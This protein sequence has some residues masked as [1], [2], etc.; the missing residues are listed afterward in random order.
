MVLQAEGIRN[1]VEHWRRN[2][3]RV[4]GTLIWQL[5]DCWP[6]ASWS[7]LDYFG[8]WKALHYAAKRFYAPVLLSVEDT[9]MRM[10]VHVTSDRTEPWSGRLAWRL[11]ALDG[12]VLDSGEQAVSA[13]PLAD[14]LLANLDFS[15]LLDE[16]QRRRTVFVCELW[17]GEAR[18]SGCVSTFVPNKHIELADPGIQVK[19][20][21]KDGQL[22]IRL[23]AKSLARFVELEFEEADAVFSDNYFDLSPN[24]P[25]A[26]SALL[27]LGW[28]IEQARRA[29]KI[30]S[31]YDSF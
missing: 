27:P 25:I 5:N 16:L 4:S 17:Q 24:Q 12:A 10:A 8:R 26:V 1:G 3:A 31:L 18:L 19:V 11:E 15:A 20:S 7:S 28:S 13:A 30:R 22:T 23:G 14:M 29:L 21:E 2:R 6:V 9:G